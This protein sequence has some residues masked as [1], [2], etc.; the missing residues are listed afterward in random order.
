MPPRRLERRYIENLHAA[1]VGLQWKIGVGT[2][3]FSLNDH[4][5]VEVLDLGVRWR[6]PS[7]DLGAIG[8]P[9]FAEGV[10]SD[11]I[12]KLAIDRHPLDRFVCM[13]A[14]KLPGYRAFR[15]FGGE[16]EGKGQVGE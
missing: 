8:L 14:G 5:R 16:T 9:V 11:H 2:V 15:W 13:E 1:L 10:V 12:Q 4:A 6:G 7:G 3:K